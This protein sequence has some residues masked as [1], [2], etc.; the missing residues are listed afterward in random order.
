[1]AGVQAPV[2]TRLRSAK[3]ALEN[4]LRRRGQARLVPGASSC[5]RL[6]RVQVETERSQ[7]D[8]LLLGERLDQAVTI[9]PQLLELGPGGEREQQVLGLD[10]VIA[11]S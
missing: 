3:R 5:G 11:G 8:P 6:Q 1:V 4:D 10:R 7:A 9:Q 2:A